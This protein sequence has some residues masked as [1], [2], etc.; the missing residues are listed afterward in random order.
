MY[1]VEK[2]RLLPEVLAILLKTIKDTASVVTVVPMDYDIAISV[3]QIPRSVV[4]D[5]PDRIITA[6]ALHLKL[7][8]VTRD[9]KIQA[10][11][12]TTIW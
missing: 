1:L 3:E 10:A 11:Q 4:P 9:H 7:P 6:T 8:L 2:G 12:V 5:M